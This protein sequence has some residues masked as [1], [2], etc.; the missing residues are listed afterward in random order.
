MYVA[1]EINLHVITAGT[2]APTGTSLP[3]AG[4]AGPSSPCLAELGRLH[5]C[6]GMM[7][8]ASEL[9]SEG[10]SFFIKEGR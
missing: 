1:G 5:G 3:D 7:A 2:A 6:G 10:E 9:S 4:R 8:R